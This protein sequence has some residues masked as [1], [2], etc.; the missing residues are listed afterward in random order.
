MEAFSCYLGISSELRDL[1][2]RNDEMGRS[3]RLVFVE[4]PDVE[5]VNRFNT[6]YLRHIRL[7]PSCREMGVLNI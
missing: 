3:N 1:C 7:V 2:L 4:L 6:G 5:F